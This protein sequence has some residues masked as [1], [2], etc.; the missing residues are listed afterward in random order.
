V[1]PFQ[2]L[3]PENFELTGQKFLALFYSTSNGP[4]RVSWGSQMGLTF[5]TTLGYYIS[6]G[7]DSEGSKSNPKNL[8]IPLKLA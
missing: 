5:L 2:L 7:V 6:T 4:P 8:T 3:Y 1:Y